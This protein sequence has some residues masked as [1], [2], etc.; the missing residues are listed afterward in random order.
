MTPLRAVSKIGNL[1]FPVSQQLMFA[2]LN[3][4]QYAILKW[5]NINNNY[6]KTH[7]QK[8]QLTLKVKLLID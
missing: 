3:Q 8:I 5:W 2:Q 7:L 6:D 1:P 4:P